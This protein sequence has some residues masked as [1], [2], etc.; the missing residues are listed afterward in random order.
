MACSLFVLLAGWHFHIGWYLAACLYLAGALSLANLLLPRTLFTGKSFSSK[1][2]NNNHQ[3]AFASGA[4]ALYTLLAL[5]LLVQDLHLDSL[6]HLSI[7]LVFP[8][9]AFALLPFRAALFYILIFAV[10]ANLLLML[11]LEGTLRAAYL[12]GFWITVLLSSLYSFTHQLRQQRLQEQLNRDPDTRLYNP[13]QLLK[14]L[15]KE[16]ER[17]Q[18]EATGLGL[19]LLQQQN[20]KQFDLPT[21]QTVSRCLSSYEGL[22]SISENRLCALIPLGSAEQLQDRTE[23][24]RQNLPDL[25][26]DQHL[27][28]ASDNPETLFELSRRPGLTNAMSEASA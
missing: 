24:L 3:Q 2:I 8:F 25:L 14:D 4:L 11:Q 17:A 18:R 28:S 16:L 26:I 1:S 12:I 13:E 21:A 27:C 6:T 22:Y 7:H 20:D 19:I 9:L 5:L 23:T 15:H 10:T